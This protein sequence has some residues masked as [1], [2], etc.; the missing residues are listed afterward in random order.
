M[1]GRRRRGH[2][3]VA[4]AAAITGLG[5][6]GSPVV[7]A[8]ASARGLATIARLGAAVPVFYGA[9]AHDVLD[10][11]SCARAQGC[12]VVGAD[13]AGRAV[14]S[15]G[16]EDEGRWTWSAAAA[17][18]GGLGGS[19]RLAGVSCATPSTCVA[20]GTDVSAQGATTFGTLHRGRWRW[21]ALSAVP[22]DP[23]GSGSLAAVS[24][25]TAVS[26]VAVGADAAGQGIVTT[27]TRTEAGWRW[28]VAAAV[29]PDASGSG[30]LTSVSCGAPTSC[31]AVGAD[32]S[33]EG[34]VTTA[35]ATGASWTWSAAASLGAGTDRLV[36]VSCAGAAWCVAVGNDGSGLGVVTTGTRTG[37]TWSW[38]LDQRPGARAA[39]GAVTCRTTRLCVAVGSTPTGRGTTGQYAVGRRAAGGLVWSGARTVPARGGAMGPLLAAS[40]AALDACAVVGAA[41]S[42]RAVVAASVARPQPIRVVAARPGNARAAVAW[43]PPAFD[44]GARIASYEVR[45]YPGGATCGVVAQ[46]GGVQRCTVG[47]LANGTRYRFTI[48]A[49]NG[50]GR[51][52]PSA[53]SAP[54]V[55]TPFRPPVASPFT[56]DVLRLVAASPDVVSA[57]VYDVLTGQT[58]RINPGSVQHTA[59]I[60]KLDILA[61]LLH[62]EQVAHVT[63]DP[64]TQQLAAEMIEASDNAAA[65]A[66]YVEI[67]QL[68]GIAAFNV[69]AGLTGT[70]PNWAWGDTGTT[71]LDQTRLVRLF[72]LPNQI[73]DTASRTFG[74]GLLEHVE[75]A[76]AWGVSSGPA[77][78]ARVALK[79]GWYPTG[80]LDWQV[81]SIGWV[82]GEGRDYVIAVLTKDNATFTVGEATIA[83]LSTI[84]WD[85]LAPRDPRRG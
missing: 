25:P 70:I 62:D 2:A 22:S 28:S 26:C 55:P 60:V 52:A 80:P 51:S 64:A 23:T 47:H 45:A 1:R 6:W 27:G 36:G 11:I 61:A 20:V 82:D 39:L 9:G 14:V 69:L 53:P 38:Q 16:T 44:G 48:T 21:T 49:D 84:V 43:R 15:A 67:G 29:T 18:R 33:S 72:A 34:I 10:A 66:L 54:V 71:S 4:L 35:V 78:G 59:S 19:G 73:L 83:A 79:N 42:G 17:L 81:N 56:P 37:A 76:Q 7:A 68:P 8:K 58:W 63:M 74:L 31:V 24:C 13:P 30:P 40:C 85:R 57:T 46:G 65:Q 12:V 75:P 32:A 5:A 3:V 50:V 41:I 77:P